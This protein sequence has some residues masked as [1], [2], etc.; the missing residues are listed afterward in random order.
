[1]FAEKAERLDWLLGW[2]FVENCEQMLGCTQPMT[3]SQTDSENFCPRL[4]YM[5]IVLFII[6][7]LIFGVWVWVTTLLTQKLTAD[8]IKNRGFWYGQLLNLVSLA[9]LFV[10]VFVLTGYFNWKLVAAF[11]VASEIGVILAGILNGLLGSS[12]S[13]WGAHG[14]WAG[15]EFALQRA[16]VMLGFLAFNLLVLVAYPVLSGISYF[17]LPATELPLRI[18]QYTLS[19]WLAGYLMTVFIVVGVLASENLDEET[20]TRY[21]INQLSGLVFNALWGA[22]LLWSFG[23]AGRGISVS[24]GSVSLVFSPL[25]LGVLIGFFVL[26]VIFPYLIGAQR[27]KKWRTSLLEKR[28]SW[29]AKLKDILE[30]PASAVYVPK[31]TDLKSALDKEIDELKASDKMIRAGTQIDENNID[32]YYEKIA[33]AYNI[34]RDQDPRFK[35]L[36][37]LRETSANLTEIIDNLSNLTTEP[38]LEEAA[39]K[40]TTYLYQ[41]RDELSKELSQIKKTRTPTVVIWSSVVIPILSGILGKFAESLWSYISK[42]SAH[43]WK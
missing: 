38:T 39:K 3:A 1:M 21:F 4:S 28:K 7:L 15:G 29:M 37:W 22:L 43:V 10:F 32:P 31:L 16:P 23:V 41:R 19:M 14:A 35:Q 5:R 26:V 36:N 42:T 11:F 27:A 20:R 25:L 13:K 12:T 34:A 24:I 30:S 2:Q 18:F 8:A 6:F 17:R 33:P 9:S 40:W